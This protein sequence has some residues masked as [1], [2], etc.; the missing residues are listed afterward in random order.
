MS[1]GARKIQLD[2]DRVKKHTKRWLCG[3]WLLGKSPLKK[4]EERG[5]ATM[6]VHSD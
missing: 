2:G 4:N 1:D 6:Q 5:A 3:M